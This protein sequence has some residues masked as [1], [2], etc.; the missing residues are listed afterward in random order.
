[1]RRIFC[2]MRLLLAIASLGFLSNLGIST[3]VSHQKVRFCLVGYSRYPYKPRFSADDTFFG[4]VYRWLA[5]LAMIGF[6]NLS[7]HF[8]VWPQGEMRIEYT[9][10]KPNFFVRDDILQKRKKLSL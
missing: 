3:R 8:F 7:K 9:K 10:E 4:R 1:M 6:K 5:P 2:T